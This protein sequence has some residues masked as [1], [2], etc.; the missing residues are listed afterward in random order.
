MAT[1]AERATSAANGTLMPTTPA[2]RSGASAIRPGRCQLAGVRIGD[3]WVPAASVPGQLDDLS[4]PYV[5]ADASPVLD[6]EPDRCVA[7]A[8]VVALGAP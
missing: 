6:A 1:S 5:L 4:G 3:V 7:D 2:T 8:R